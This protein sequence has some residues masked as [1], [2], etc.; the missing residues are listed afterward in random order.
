MAPM[1]GPDYINRQTHLID[2]EARRGALRARNAREAVE[3]R[4][5]FDEC[6]PVEEAA[7]R[8]TRVRR[9]GILQRLFSGTGEAGRTPAGVNVDLQRAYCPPGTEPDYSG[10]ECRPGRPASKGNPR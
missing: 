1:F 8:P 10:S 4:C 2:E 7:A 9:R 3:G 5:A 6:D